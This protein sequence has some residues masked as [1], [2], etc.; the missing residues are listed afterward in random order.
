ME[1]TRKAQNLKKGLPRFG[2]RLK[3][4][5]RRFCAMLLCASMVVGGF[6]STFFQAF[7]SIGSEEYCYELERESLCE[8]LLTAISEDMVLSRELD[9]KGE[10]AEQYN[11]L[12]D[13]DGTLYE[14]KD[15]K[16]EKDRERDKILDLRVFARIEGDI[17]LDKEYE[18][19]GGETVIFLLTNKAKDATSAVIRI[20]DIE[21]E[22]IEIIPASSVSREKGP[23]SAAA[24]EGKAETLDAV[25]GN[26]ASA[27]GAGNSQVESSNA[28]SGNNDTGDK[29]NFESDDA[30]MSETD[31]GSGES[32]EDESFM[33]DGNV[34]ENAPS[35][36]IPAENA[37]DSQDYEDEHSENSDT[38]HAE[39]ADDDHSGDF[40]S[41]TEHQKD[42]ASSGTDDNDSGS[43]SAKNESDGKDS[44]DNKDDSGNKD[45]PDGKD[46]SD[47]KDTSKDE[48]GS[49]SKTS[50]A[51]EG[52][53]TAAVSAHRV[54]LLASAL[55]GIVIEQEDD[56]AV[57]IT[58]DPQITIASVSD[59]ENSDDEDD[60][61]DEKA[62]VA[63]TV[64][65]EL[66][67]A[68]LIDAKK[69][70]V[71]FATT[72]ED[73]GIDRYSNL[74]D[75]TI[76]AKIYSDS[77]YDMRL[78]DG[79]TITLTGMMPM[80]AEVK[81]YPVDVEIEDVNVL[82]AYDIAI[83]DRN[84][85][86]FQPDDDV[87]EVLIK[88]D[89][90]YEALDYDHEL[91]VYHMEDEF[92]EPEE[93]ATIVP[94][95]RRLQ[96]LSFPAEKFSIYVVGED[97]TV[98]DENGNPRYTVNFYKWVYDQNTADKTLLETQYAFGKDFLIEPTVPEI[99][100][101]VFEGWFTEV[102]DATHWDDGKYPGY[103][104]NFNMTIEDNLKYW[105][106][107]SIETD[108]V[109]NLYSDYDPI[110]YVYYMTEKGEDIDP[111]IFYTDEYY[112]NN[113]I[114]DTSNAESVYQLSHLKNN[115]AI[116]HWYYYDE[117][118]DEQRI[119]NG[120]VIT[121]NLIL[122]PFIIDA[123]WIYF[124]LGDEA[125]KNVEAIDPKSIL[126]DATT[127]G[128]LPE[129]EIPGYEFKGWFICEEGSG[130]KIYGPLTE[131][132]N[133]QILFSDGDRE[134]YI[135]LYAEWNPL[136]VSYTVNIWRQK[137]TD[138]QRG[139]DQKVVLDG[140]I[141]KEYIKYY[142]Y[143][144][145]I[146]VSADDSILITGTKPDKSILDNYNDK[147]ETVYQGTGEYNGFEYNRLRSENDIADKVMAADGSTVINVF[148]D[149]VTIEWYFHNTALSNQANA[150]H[151]SNVE[152]SLI[153]LYGT[154]IT[155]VNGSS[156][157]D[158]CWDTWT[159]HKGLLGIS[160]N[161][162]MSADE[163][164]LSILF[165]TEYVFKRTENPTRIDFWHSTL[166]LDRYV[167]YYLEV[168][169]AAQIDESSEAAASAKS[170]GVPYT[171]TIDGVTYVFNRAVRM[172]ST[173][174]SDDYFL[175][176]KFI[177]YNLS[178]KCHVSR[179]TRNPENAT[180][181]NMSDI[182]VGEA[183]SMGNDWCIYSDALEYQIYLFSNNGSELLPVDSFTYKYGADLTG[184]E[185]PKELDDKFGPNYYYSFPG[186][187]YEDPTFTAEFQKPDT[188]PN[189]N[190]VA[191]AKWE[192][193]KVT[194]T[195]RS[196][197][198]SN[199]YDI[200][201]GFYGKENV[202]VIDKVE[203]SDPWAYSVV[204]TAGDD[205]YSG[206]NSALQSNSGDHNYEYAGWINADTNKVFNFASRLY[207]D[208][209]LEL[210]WIED[211]TEFHLMYYID[212]DDEESAVLG[213]SHESTSQAQV[214][215]LKDL[216]KDVSDDSFICWRHINDDNTFIDY[217][218]D[219]YIDFTQ[220][221]TRAVYKED[222]NGELKFQYFVYDLYPV[223]EE[224]NSVVLILDYN[225]PNGYNDSSNPDGM[226]EVTSLKLSDIKIEEVSD[227]N[228]T[229]IVSDSSEY[230]ETTY[231]LIGWSEN[232]DANFG[233]NDILPITATVAVT[234]NK[235]AEGEEEKP[236]ILYAVWEA[237]K[238][239]N[240]VDEKDY[241]GNPVYVGQTITYTITYLN[242]T[243]EEADITVTDTLDKGLTYIRS[244]PTGTYDENSNTVAW[245]ILNVGPGAAGSIT[246]T[247]RVNE[248]AS[249]T[250]VKNEAFV[251]VGN[252]E[253][254]T[255]E[256][257]IP[258]KRYL[259]DIYKYTSVGAENN[260]L[261]GA[262]FI[263]SKLVITEDKGT[264]LE[265]EH[266]YY[267]SF[268]ERDVSGDGIGKSTYTLN[269]WSEVKSDATHLVS[270]KDGY[271]HLENID[272]DNYILT[273]IKAPD[274]YVL[275]AEP[276]EFIVDESGSVKVTGDNASVEDEEKNTILIENK[277]GREL[278]STG[279]HGT[280]PFTLTGI[281]M[282][283]GSALIYL[284]LR[285]RKVRVG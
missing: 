37:G 128:D 127:I 8:A 202:T 83:F 31:F 216:F 147:G 141:Y 153:G 259:V 51:S 257:D 158:G 151:M 124:I 32:S 34:A 250:I 43:D 254:V 146:T 229:I 85:K 49:D 28:E 123:I 82:A 214:R 160:Y 207:T 185:L 86:E 161:W 171:R 238:T 247:A 181:S 176:N 35:E 18:I 118:G 68:V 265:E 263:L 70:A 140:E 10:Y 125:G 235:T 279:G 206:L 255:G 188:M 112:E 52:S 20:D 2:R 191:Y 71:A 186:I 129:P 110:Y 264:G 108:N 5:C 282:M 63:D 242:Y 142:D 177:G 23:G 134:R 114:L 180:Y 152:G 97:G 178:Q 60:T 36:N 204:I 55:P 64:N 57:M 184:F 84:G 168:T 283:S 41:A 38:E 102:Q 89:A 251:V 14:L 163:G 165:E 76:Q 179:N 116:D 1:F 248:N 25:S 74:E 193:N 54:G 80:E 175:N 258:L 278:P 115:Q 15:L 196:N 95:P 234:E 62:V 215:E 172:V 187:W 269:G 266:I 243:D 219:D 195:F 65:G 9:F 79:T 211:Q 159:L 6:P 199:L 117:H 130:E 104:Y 145:S 56:T 73:L 262:E 277:A 213:N 183:I 203:D 91:T 19:N 16:I 105:E 144:E 81:A 67:D 150:N 167:I 209:T 126:W 210:L 131:N 39:N 220:V 93:I 230:G 99:E 241:T 59:A 103:R 166:S 154:N 192:L 197:V 212:P 3:D 61:A 120:T 237:V 169:N 137:A 267:G 4:R 24:A 47:S 53:D 205:L 253:A 245:T 30:I 274:G 26:S 162:V 11:E 88:N 136:R 100:H 96:T 48:S 244:E 222:E 182:T 228:P 260:P 256:V 44:A 231:W 143:A 273:E 249:G 227:L 156:V 224:D 69:A 173:S 58:D 50:S 280:L 109:I 75:Q 225:Y 157:P 111:V 261:A 40:E 92:D 155:P 170:T 281:L 268:I 132:F 113:A 46:H 218:P 77:S 7:A 240:Q 270:S 284:A 133:P 275:L 21:T 223:W 246:L 139:L 45:N 194:V 107:Y 135:N 239:V 42:D 201:I 236:N 272:P 22:T 148:Y 87:I 226:K 29:E 138:G 33:E 106:N 17:P 276:V 121:E 200:L 101:H 94:A 189:N 122:Y 90:I 252:E 119:E 233:D 164:T 198:D 217:Y 78:A 66:Y 12:F 149:R 190:L 208:I 285:R 72:T 232:P 271:I 98:T 13:A 27:G 174:S 221:E